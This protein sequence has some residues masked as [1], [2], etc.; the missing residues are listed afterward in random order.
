MAIPGTKTLTID[1]GET[2]SDTIDLGREDVVGFAIP[3][4][5][6]GTEVTPKGRRD[7]SETM[8]PIN[9]EGT[10]QAWTVAAGDN[11]IISAEKLAG[12]KQLSLTSNAAQ[13]GADAEIEILTRRFE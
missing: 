1:D 10:A 13:S 8:G 5:F 9:F 12:I 3:S 4:D 7:S 6:D 2:V 11:L